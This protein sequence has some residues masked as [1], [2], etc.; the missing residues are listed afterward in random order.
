MIV[1]VMIVVIMNVWHVRGQDSCHMS[2]ARN[3]KCIHLM[4]SMLELI[5]KQNNKIYYALI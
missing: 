5:I 2:E 3:V 1:M 4:D